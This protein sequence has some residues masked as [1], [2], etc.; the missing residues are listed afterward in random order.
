ME[1]WVK[2][3]VTSLLKKGVT[4]L[5]TGKCT[6]ALERLEKIVTSEPVL[7]PPDQDQQFILEVDASQF[8]TGAILYQADRKMTD[9]KGNPILQPC[10]YHS[11]TFSTTEQCYPIYD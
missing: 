10:G 11:Q 1:M 8:V 4:F 3:R 6:Q 9:Q 2:H 7:V 5:W